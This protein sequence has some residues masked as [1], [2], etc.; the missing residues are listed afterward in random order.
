MP[1]IR[2]SLFAA[3]F[4][5]I[6]AATLLTARPA[7]AGPPLLCFPFNI[8]AART[9]PMAQTGWHDTDPKYDVAR[10]VQDTVGLLGADT[11]II[12]RME[13]LR[14][15]TVYAGAN[16]A[17]A[18]ALLTKLEERARA[19]QPDA[20][21]AVFDFGYLAETYRQA[22]LMFKNALPSVDAIDGYSLV[23]KAFAFRHDPEIEF[24]SAII[25]TWPKR[26]EFE[27]HRRN[28]ESGAK[29]DSLLAANLATHLSHP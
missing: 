15:A 26:A 29:A 4:V 17:I 10:L 16:P 8:G 24:A 7:L 9:L 12:V 27:T 18:A 23:R 6:G 25:A 5:T 22:A 19:A 13:T 3:V 14:R 1:R 21:L 20:A 28:A 11:P 2:P